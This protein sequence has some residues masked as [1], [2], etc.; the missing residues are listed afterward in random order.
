MKNI[1]RYKRVILDFETTGLNPYE[2]EILQVSAIDENGT[3]LIDEY[4]KPYS[5]ERWEEA[6][7][8]HGITPDFIRDKPYFNKFRDKL[9][10]ILCNAE[11]IIIYNV[12]F[13]LGFLDKY[14]V[15]YKKEGIEYKIPRFFCMMEAFAEVY[16]DFN[17]YYGSYTWK[18]LEVCCNYYGYRN[19]NAHNGL[20]DCKATLYCYEKLKNNE[21]NIMLQN[22][23]VD[24]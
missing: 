7:L 17:I 12:N 20:E 22:I 9:S 19:N 21:K 24:L 14:G 5:K 16:G 1:F 18:S 15:E 4:C 3:V 10:S 8:I 23:L 2:D 13:E 6:Q 11:E